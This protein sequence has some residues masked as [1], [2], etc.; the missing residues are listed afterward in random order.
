MWSRSSV[1]SLILVAST[2][3]LLRMDTRAL[4]KDHQIIPFG[5]LLSLAGSTLPAL[6]RLDLAS[7]SANRG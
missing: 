2:V 4:N 3:G 1:S 6:A 7:L 5:Y